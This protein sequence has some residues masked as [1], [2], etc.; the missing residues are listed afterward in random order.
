M[1][2]SK[3]FVDEAPEELILSAEALQAL[4]KDAVVLALKEFDAEQKKREEEIA[5]AKFERDIEWANM[6]LRM[7]YPELMFDDK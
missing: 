1:A 7:N 3:Q 2:T 5:N 4:I 6:R